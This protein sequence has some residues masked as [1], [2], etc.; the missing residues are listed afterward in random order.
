MPVVS[1]IMPM[2]NA[3]RFV[4]AALASLLQEQT[5]PIEVIVVDDGSTDASCKRVKQMQDDRILLLHSP[6]QGTANTLNLALSAVQGEIVMRC[7]ADD[8]FPPHRIAEQVEWLTQHPEYGAVCG[9]FTTMDVNEQE[10]LAFNCGNE[11]MDI[12]AELQQGITRAHLGTFAIRRE[13][14]QTIGGCR[15]YFR[16]GEDIDVQLR[17]AEVCRVWYQPASRYQYRLHATSL[18]HTLNSEERNF[19]D[20]IAR[21]FRH[22]RAAQGTDALQQGCPPIPPKGTHVLDANQHIQG[23]LL[24]K[25]WHEHSTGQKLKAIMTGLQ[26]IGVRPQGLAAWRNLLVL[27]LKSPGQKRVVPWEAGQF[28]AFYE[29]R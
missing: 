27:L 4:T 11:S 2:Y 14:L 9:S 19:F 25:S 28:Q 3:E 10:I 24:G 29:E 5:I 13:V 26:S 23:L 22:Q 21:E 15:S 18:T 12:T 8:R 1:I 6:H 20:K 16:S 17:I 7:D